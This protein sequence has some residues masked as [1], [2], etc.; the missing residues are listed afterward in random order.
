MRDNRF[1]SIRLHGEARDSR[2][3]LYQWP[4]LR[5]EIERLRDRRNPSPLRRR[6]PDRQRASD[7]SLR[8]RLEAATQR[9]RELDAEDRQL[10]DALG[11]QRV[12]ALLWS[13]PDTPRK[14]RTL[15]SGHADG[16]VVNT[17]HHASTQ[18]SDAGTG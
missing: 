10:R 15:L 6:V 14:S 11:E 2:S 4:G 13:S 12:A 18:V 17:G 5:S 8:R 1:R 9:N 3:W 7:A 16:R